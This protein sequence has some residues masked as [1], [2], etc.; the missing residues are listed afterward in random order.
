MRTY[1]VVNTPDLE[2][3]VKAYIHYIAKDLGNPDAASRVWKDYKE[4]RKSLKKNAGSLPDPESIRLKQLGLKRINFIAHDY[5]LLF[6][7]RD[8]DTVIVTNM[9]HFKE[10]YENKLR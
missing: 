6:R 7:I 10:D 4:T 9:F 8:D 1:K 5:F 3:Q 2:M